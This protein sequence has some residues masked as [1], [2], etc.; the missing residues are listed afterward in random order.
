[1][2]TERLIGAWQL[3]SWFEISPDG[4]IAYPMGEDSVGQIIYTA[5]GR[6]S[7]QIARGNPERFRDDD[8]RKASEAESATAFMQYF[9]YFGRYSVDA[10]RETVTHHIEG[11]AFPN[12][13]GTRQVRHYRFEDSR[14]ILDADTAW[15]RVRVVW[16]RLTEVQHG[17]GVSRAVAG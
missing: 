13:V 14:L 3:E 2:M 6:I 1:M 10:E 17:D 8:W 16:K 7:A 9:G 12:L 15:G 11:A 4:T 5:D